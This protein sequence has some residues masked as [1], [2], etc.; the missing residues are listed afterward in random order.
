MSSKMPGL[1]VGVNKKLRGSKDHVGLNSNCD[2]EFWGSNPR[3][4]RASVEDEGEGFENIGDFILQTELTIHHERDVLA[5]VQP[6][7]HYSQQ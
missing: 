2:I 5:V 4:R 7:K 6:V 1:R 3:G